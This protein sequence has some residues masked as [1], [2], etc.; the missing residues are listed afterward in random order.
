MV[1]SAV[2]DGPL[3]AG[4]VSSTFP[5]PVPLRPAAIV[6]HGALVLVVHAQPP[7]AVTFTV[8][9][10]GPCPAVYHVGLIVSAQVGVGDGVGVGEGGGGCGVGDG[11]VGA[12]ASA[13]WVT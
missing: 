7:A 9:L 2:R 5:L 10:S 4:I 6:T 11:G 1:T 3:F 13:D 12:V 8:T